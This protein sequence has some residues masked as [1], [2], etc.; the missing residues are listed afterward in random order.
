MKDEM[1]KIIFF[2]SF[3][4]SSSP[5]PPLSPLL[6]RENMSRT[7]RKSRK[8]VARPPTIL[9]EPFAG[10]PCASIGHCRIYIFALIDPFDRNWANR[11]ARWRNPAAL[12]IPRSWTNYS[13]SVRPHPRDCH[14]RSSRANRRPPCVSVTSLHRFI[15]LHAHIVTHY[16]YVTTTCRALIILR[17]RD[18]CVNTRRKKERRDVAL[19][20]CRRKQA[21]EATWN[22]SNEL[23]PSYGI[24]LRDNFRHGS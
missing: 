9:R 23:I 12:I 10:Q 18:T 6:P 24:A 1:S 14:P 16:V 17:C 7:S 2:R 13:R 19:F 4:F 21:A 15:Y 8:F 3:L 20:T 11:P 22:F 5:L